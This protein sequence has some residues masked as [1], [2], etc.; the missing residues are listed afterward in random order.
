MFFAIILQNNYEKR[1]QVCKIFVPLQAFF[2]NN[3]TKL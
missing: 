1:L 2:V 3:A